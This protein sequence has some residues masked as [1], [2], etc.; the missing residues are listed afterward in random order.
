MS[1]PQIKS[2]VVSKAVGDGLAVYDRRQQRSH[3][4]NATSALV[5]QHCDGRTTPQQLTEFLRV[6]F[7]LLRGQA[8]QLVW[9]ALSEL[10]KAGLLQASV[11]TTQ[12]PRSLLNRRQALKGLA[13][14]GLSL[15]LMPLVSSQTSVHAGF[16]PGTTT[17]PAPTTTTTP[18]PTEPPAIDALTGPIDPVSIGSS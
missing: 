14:A 3:V 8:E 17:T 7:N 13:I 6:K 1:N 2:N 18:P 4:L 11:T 5:F 12:A 16:T 15:A 9:L 10:E